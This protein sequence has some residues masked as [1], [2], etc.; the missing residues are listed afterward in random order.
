MP[1][2]GCDSQIG[3]RW[4]LSQMPQRAPGCAASGKLFRSDR[5]ACNQSRN[6]LMSRNLCREL[7]RSGPPP[8]ILRAMA[9]AP[10]NAADAP[11]E[12]SFVDQDRV[13]GKQHPPPG[14]RTGAGPAWPTAWPGPGLAGRPGGR[15]RPVIAAQSATAASRYS[16]L[17]PSPRSASECAA[18]RS[19]DVKLPPSG[20]SQLSPGRLTP[21]AIGDRRCPALQSARNHPSW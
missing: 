5:L 13:V 18:T 16:T 11:A 3:E 7:S 2:I 9:E 15:R 21:G 20:R 8:W 10:P 12:T 19:P 1:F 14:R 4:L 17:A 6:L